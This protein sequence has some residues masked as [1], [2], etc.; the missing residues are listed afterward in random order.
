MKGERHRLVSNTV[1]L[2][3]PVKFEN[4]APV[5]WVKEIGHKPTAT[6]IGSSESAR[7]ADCQ[8]WGGVAEGH[9]LRT[10]SA[11]SP[12]PVYRLGHGNR[13]AWQDRFPNSSGMD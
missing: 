13:A 5:V 1:P 7:T 12:V 10:T 6:L 11:P 3:Q 2:S 4:R 9:R 8:R